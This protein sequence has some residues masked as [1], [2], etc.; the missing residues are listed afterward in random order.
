[1]RL[2]ERKSVAQQTQ[3]RITLTHL[4]SEG[5]R[6]AATSSLRISRRWLRLLAEVCL[7]QLLYQRGDVARV[8]S[9]LH[10]LG[11]YRPTWQKGDTG[12]GNRGRGDQTLTYQTLLINTEGDE[13]M[14]YHV[15]SSIRPQQDLQRPKQKPSG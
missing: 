15:Y 9:H 5:W 6:V 2:T 1:M 3:H 4:G 8:H 12:W 7:R 13:V 14:R 11:G 10:L